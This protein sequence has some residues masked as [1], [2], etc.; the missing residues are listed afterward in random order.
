MSLSLN[1]SK[2]IPS[3]KTSNGVGKGMAYTNARLI[4]RPDSDWLTSETIQ[5]SSSEAEIESDMEE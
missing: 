3:I 5:G 1:I 2:V 4:T